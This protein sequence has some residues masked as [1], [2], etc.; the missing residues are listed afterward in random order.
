M[1]RKRGEVLDAALEVSGVDS[2]RMARLKLVKIAMIESVMRKL[3]SYSLKDTGKEQ[4][5]E[6][7]F[8]N[9]LDKTASNVAVSDILNAKDIRG[10]VDIILKGIEVS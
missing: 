9:T 6:E 3:N 7:E 1:L 2:G 10:K 8:E 5:N 4:W